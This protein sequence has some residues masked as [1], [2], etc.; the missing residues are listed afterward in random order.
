MIIVRR[1]RFSGY[2]ETPIGGATYFPGQVTTKLV[3][4]PLEHG[5][6]VLEKV[7]IEPLKKKSSRIKKIVGPLKKILRGKNNNN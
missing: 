3:L 4:D 7:P 6:E 1:K 5:A 2:S